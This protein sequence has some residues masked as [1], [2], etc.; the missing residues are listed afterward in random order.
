MGALLGGA[1]VSFFTGVQ[2]QVQADCPGAP[3][4]A[5]G[6]GDV[7]AS[8]S[9]DLGDAIYLLNYL[10]VSGPQ[11]ADITPE[12]PVP[13]KPSLVFLVRH[14]EVDDAG[15]QTQ[16]G[17]ARVAELLRHFRTTRITHVFSSHLYWARDTA[18][19][20][21]DAHDLEVI[22]LPSADWSGP[23]EDQIAPTVEAL[24]NLPEG[25]SAIVVGHG[26][27]LYGIMAGIGVH[28][29]TTADPCEP[30]DTSCLPCKSI[31]CFPGSDFG[32]LWVVSISPSGLAEAAMVRLDFGP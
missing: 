31:S 8:G 26:R 2:V 15:L 27:T 28:V 20:L 10:F 30:G 1:L 25:S 5:C 13:P 12:T 6:N 32:G 14:V 17:Q 29:H 23:R 7:N 3:G 21:A 19:P 18:Q 16:L 9:I 22:Q 11:P 24:K 4:Q